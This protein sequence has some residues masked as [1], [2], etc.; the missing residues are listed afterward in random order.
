MIGVNVAIKDKSLLS[1]IQQLDR[2]AP[3]L[4]QDAGF[5]VARQLEPII[6]VDLQQEPPPLPSGVFK[7]LATPKQFRYVMAKLAKA[8]QLKEGGGHYQ[9]TH[10]ATQGWQVVA[11]LRKDGTVIMIRNPW[12]GSKFL[13]GP[14]QQPFHAGRWPTLRRTP[15][16]RTYFIKYDRMAA[17]MMRAELYA[18]LR[19]LTKGKRP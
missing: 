15:R 4:V 13:W 12:E 19:A 2:A 5:A 18:R 17:D 8:G 6:E 9:R 1:V 3:K 7:A 11:S 16:D 14:Q 10:A